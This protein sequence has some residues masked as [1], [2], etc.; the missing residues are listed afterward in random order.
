MKIFENRK[1]RGAISIFLVMILI[2]T[3][4]LSAVLIDGSRLAS[5]RA[6]T[7]EAADL[8]ALSVLSSYDLERRMSSGCSPWR[9][10]KK[11]R[12]YTGRA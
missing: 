10:A 12:P 4:L 3:M 1:T 6:M 8:A 9:T 7:Q 2:P 5:A 11:P